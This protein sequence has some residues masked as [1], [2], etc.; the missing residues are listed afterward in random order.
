[1]KISF[2]WSFLSFVGL[3][4][5]PPAS[6]QAI[7]SVPFICEWAN[8]AG[9]CP[10]GNWAHSANCGP[11]SVLMVADAYNN[12]LPIAQQVNLADDW[13]YA[14]YGTTY[15]N[16]LANNYLGYGTNTTELAALADGEFSLSNVVAFSG[17]TVSQLQ[18]ELANGYPVVVYVY[19]RMEIASHDAHYMVLLGMD[20]EN[21]YVDDPGL[22]FGGQ[23]SATDTTPGRAYPIN[24]FSAAWAA[25]GNSGVSIHP[26]QAG[27]FVTVSAALDGGAWPSSGISPVSYS[28]TGP[29]GP[30]A[31]A[32]LVP[33]ETV[34][35][36]P[37][38]TYTLTFTSGG[39]TNSA[40]SDILPCA[41]PLI[42]ASCTA[43]LTAGQNL[44]FTL[45]FAGNLPTA[46]FTMSGLSPPPVT[47]T[48][49]NGST[50]TVYTSPGGTASV[51]F[52]G[53]T[54]STATSGASITGWQWMVNGSAVATVPTFT[55]SLSASASTG[56]SITY[57]IILVVTDSNG[58]QSQPAQGT[59][60]VSN[61]IFVCEIQ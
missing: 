9:G 32:G 38:G 6:G 45:Q 29:T 53:S 50:L 54:R 13:L 52:D 10:S 35:N 48:K 8:T 15:G 12:S 36:L 44:L 57:Q 42:N 49:N 18:Q 24:Q 25:H 19:A 22:Q 1:V 4:G 58:A 17:W 55:Q 30:V 40:L 31:G 11:T 43:T 20:S 46:G 33:V 47:V 5:L 56:Q 34:A 28:I 41:T 37:P 27:G 7:L 61:C 39:P 16:P 21:V 51:T 14:N 59:V 26:N 23:R 3:F 60:V 2:A